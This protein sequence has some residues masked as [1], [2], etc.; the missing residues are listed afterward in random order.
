M[1]LDVWEQQGDAEGLGKSYKKLTYILIDWAWQV[2][3][4]QLDTP[5]RATIG[6]V[7]IQPNT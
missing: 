5:R 3:E 1:A 2:E 4:R 6:A 7:L